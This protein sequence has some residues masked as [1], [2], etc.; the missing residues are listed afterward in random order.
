MDH[1]SFVKCSG[2]EEDEDG[3]SNTGWRTHRS[4]LPRATNAVAGALGLIEPE[5]HALPGS[6]PQDKIHFLIADISDAFWL[7]PFDPKERRVFL[8]EYRGR[9][10][11][12]V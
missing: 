4:T 1:G 11:V 12:F 8:A 2:I 9:W 7:V 5:S 6:T 3:V 10:L